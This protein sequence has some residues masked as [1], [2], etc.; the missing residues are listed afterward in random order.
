MDWYVGCWPLA[1]R[2][3]VYF[4]QFKHTGHVYIRMYTSQGTPIDTTN[5]KMNTKHGIF[6]HIYE[7]DDTIYFKLF[8]FSEELHLYLDDFKTLYS[9]TTC[10]K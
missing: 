5:L 6:L 9:D 3:R 4:Q 1:A 2:Q 7:L 8:T 10:N